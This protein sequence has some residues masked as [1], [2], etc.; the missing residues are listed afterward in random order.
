MGGG[1]F[2]YGF[3]YIFVS[4]EFSPK[5]ARKAS[6]PRLLIPSEIQILYIYILKN[7]VFP[8]VQ[9]VI[10]SRSHFYLMPFNGLIKSAHVNGISI[11][12][13]CNTTRWEYFECLYTSVL[14]IYLLLREILMEKLQTPL[15]KNR[16]WGVEPR[17]AAVGLWPAW[18]RPPSE[19]VRE[20]CKLKPAR[21][22]EI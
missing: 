5:A 2:E 10:V 12:K 1:L 20:A 15:D 18:L 14:F 8:W 22:K 9:A 16:R 11:I 19:L 6:S 17:G 4:G 13:L 7:P 21:Q 3:L